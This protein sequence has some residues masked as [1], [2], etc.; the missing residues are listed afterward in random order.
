MY[1]GAPGMVVREADGGRVVQAM[2]WGFS[3]PQK[4][5]KTGL[6]IKPK[7]VNN[8]ADLSSLMWRHIKPRPEHR[9]LI[10]LTGFAEAEGE[11]GA[12][13]RTWFRVKGQAVFAWAGMW[14]ESGEWGAVYS[15]LMTN[16][17]A[18]VEPV[19][20]R[21][22]ALLLPDEWD[23]WLHGSLEDG[24]AFQDRCFPAELTLIKRTAEPWMRKLSAQ[25]PKSS[26]ATT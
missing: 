5:N 25:P 3:L 12:K 1:P 8:I 18:T 6:P 4:S 9:C 19:H 16:A 23:C 14:K 7:P 21:M 24:R 26:M 15:G 13:T 20:H 17:N 10:P 2:T 11:Q 22:P